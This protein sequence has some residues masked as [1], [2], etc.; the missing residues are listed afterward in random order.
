MVLTA[1]V[2]PGAVDLERARLARAAPAAAATTARVG[3][4]RSAGAAIAPVDSTAA[5]R[6]RIDR[7]RRWAEGRPGSIAF[8]VVGRDGTVRGHQEHAR[9]PSAS[10]VKAMLLAAEL[11]R[12]A[13]AGDPLDPATRSLLEAM[14]TYSDNDAATAIY[15]RVGD[16]GLNEVARRVG[17]EDFEV[18]VSW[19]YAEVSAA[20]MALLFAALDELLPG[21]HARFGKGLLG[22]IVPDQSWGIAAAAAD[23]WSVRFKGGW[24]TTEAGQLV[25][26]AA[27][28]RD[29]RRRL[30][31]AVLTDGQPSMAQG[32]ETVAGVAGRLLG[33]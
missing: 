16:G 4:P 23:R 11:R 17:M 21:R 28:L 7:A 8:A 24:R 30:A 3:A 22:S 18:A 6:R 26:Q 32:V 12:L 5:I 10:V 19:G 1:A 15:A 29:G 25:H 2:D 27:E 13:A 9:F 31:I 20:D 14:I 33:G